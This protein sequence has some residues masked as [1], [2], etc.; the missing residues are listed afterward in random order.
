MSPFDV[1]CDFARPAGI[2]LRQFG[3]AAGLADDLEAGR[4]GDPELLIEDRQVVDDIGIV[5]GIDDRDGLAGAIGSGGG[6][7]AE[8]DLIEA[9]C[10][11]DL[12]RG[13]ALH[14]GVDRGCGVAG[15][16][17]VGLIEENR[18]FED[19]IGC[20]RQQLPRFESLDQEGHGLCARPPARLD[21]ELMVTTS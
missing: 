13:V 12:R 10:L 11:A 17:G 19:D 5:V 9:V 1:E 6:T 20:R 18:G 7:R 8:A 4:S 2:V 16:G 3:G 14:G 15:A 21:C